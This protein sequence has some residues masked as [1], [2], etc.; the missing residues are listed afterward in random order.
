MLSEEELQ[1]KAWGIYLG[2]RSELY[3]FYSDQADEEG[4]SAVYKAGLEAG[5]KIFNFGPV[6]GDGDVVIIDGEEYKARFIEED[7]NEAYQSD[8]IRLVLIKEKT[9][10]HS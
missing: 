6:L 9:D 5:Q 4:I 10:D 2:N 3:N 1:D 7:Y 8:S